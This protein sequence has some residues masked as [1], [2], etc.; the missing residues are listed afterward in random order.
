MNKQKNAHIK[1]RIA[2]N[3]L[4]LLLATIPTALILYYIGPLILVP[5]KTYTLQQYFLLGGA[6]HILMALIGAMFE[7]V[8]ILIFIFLIPGLIFA[9]LILHL[10][11]S[12]NPSLFGVVVPKITLAL[13]L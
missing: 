6:A 4:R 10:L 7:E 11:T 3:V 2:L 5:E 9:D 8:P 13:Y 1:N 12:A